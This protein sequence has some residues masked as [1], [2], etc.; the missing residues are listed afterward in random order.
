M[1]CVK[2]GFMVS[3]AY[4][5]G[6]REASVLWLW[7]IWRM[8]EGNMSA[9]GYPTIKPNPLTGDERI[10]Q[11]EERLIS[12]WR[13]AHSN[14]IDNAE[15]GAFAEY[16]VHIAM[17]AVEPTRVN[18]D[19]YDVKSPEGIAIEVKTSGY[20]QSWAQSR[21]SSITFSIRP[22]YGWDS[23]TN[24]Y[25]SE[26]TRQSDV[27]V[28]CLHAHKNQETIDPLDMA[29]WKFY[30]LPTAVLN[31]KVGSQKTISLSGVIQ[32]GGKETD[33]GGLRDAVLS[34]A[35]DGR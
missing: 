5:N 17:N 25:A 3:L 1:A 34:A 10:T 29:Q 19:R 24:A 27:Y 4:A 18:W 21:L 20:I 2:H 11:T 15:R 14:L 6:L 16:M 28:F 12:Y 9:N 7:R 33:F 30:V 35:N 26:R 32:L 13:W 31:D 22:T 23:E 8:G